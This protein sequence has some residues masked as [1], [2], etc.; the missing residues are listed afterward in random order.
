MA[1]HWMA[2][3]L[4]SACEPS[5]F[6][7]VALP[8]SWPLNPAL[9]HNPQVA[10]SP[11]AQRPRDHQAPLHSSRV[12]LMLVGLVLGAGVEADG[13]GTAGGRAPPKPPPANQPRRRP[14]KPDP[15]ALFSPPPTHTHQAPPQ[16]AHGHG[17]AGV[18][19][20]AGRAGD[21]AGLRAPRRPGAGGEH[22]RERA[23]R[24]ARLLGAW[25]ACALWRAAPLSFGRKACSFHGSPS[26]H[27]PSVPPTLTPPPELQ[28][29]HPTP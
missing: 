19:P 20:T 7:G 28:K 17:P 27:P 6:L 16:V 22:P 4:P 3:G 25:G 8:R 12:R 1:D 21:G 11:E 26:T 29:T 18:P 23:P 5:S 14:A 2:A 10:V 15:A 9:F 24:T 13:V